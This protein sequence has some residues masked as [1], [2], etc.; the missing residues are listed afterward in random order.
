MFSSQNVFSFRTN[1]CLA[2]AVA[3]TLACV[4]SLSTMKLPLSMHTFI[5]VLF[6]RTLRLV[7]HILNSVCDVFGLTRLAENA[8]MQWW[9]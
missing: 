3:E 8:T 4:E 7:V 5:D 9:R 1:L 6:D 2:M